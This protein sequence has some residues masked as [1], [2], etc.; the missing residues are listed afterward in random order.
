MHRPSMTIG[1]KAPLM[2]RAY[3][4]NVR[5][6]SSTVF[7][8]IPALAFVERPVVSKCSATLAFTS[9]MKRA[10]SARANR[11][12]VVCIGVLLRE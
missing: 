6:S 2:I 1:V 9:G 8:T 5:L 3:E 4:P 11:I 10:E 12:R 7:A